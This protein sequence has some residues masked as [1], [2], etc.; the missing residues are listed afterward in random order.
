MLADFPPVRHQREKMVGTI[1]FHFM[2]TPRVKVLRRQ[3][4]SE[5]VSTVVLCCQ[6]FRI[7]HVFC[8]QQRAGKGVPRS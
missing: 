5:H 1:R 6:E 8:S 3:L 4:P 7:H 2:L